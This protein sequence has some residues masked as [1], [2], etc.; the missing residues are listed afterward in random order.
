[1]K[2]GLITPLHL[3]SS[4]NYRARMSEEK[5]Q[6]IEKA[7]AY[8]FDY[9]DGDR[10]Y[11]YGGYRYDGRWAEVA[12]Q[13]ISQY[14][15]SSSSSV[16]DLGCGK[17]HLLFELKK[18]LPD[19]RVV[20]ADMSHYAIENSPSEIRNCL[21]ERDLRALPLPFQSQEFDLVLAIN[22]LH[23]FHVGELFGLIKEIERIGKD[24][25]ILV[26]SYRTAQ[27]LINLQCWALTCV[28]F[29]NELD[30]EWI[31]N[32]NGFTGDYEFIFFENSDLK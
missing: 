13:L 21:V 3:S 18:L 24:K 8:A 11:G 15:L 17:A 27:E 16:L 10:K 31:F 20:G 9:W 19:I 12:R 6:C 22:T 5:A 28:A 29:Y 2:I 7:S 14:H 23:N 1:M 25:F 4:R 30:W 32:A 26:E